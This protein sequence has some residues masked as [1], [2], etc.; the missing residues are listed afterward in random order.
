MRNKKQETRMKIFL[1]LLIGIALEMNTMGEASREMDTMGAANFFP[2]AYITERPLRYSPG[3]TLWMKAILCNP[4][5]YE[6][7]TVNITAN[8]PFVNWDYNNGNFAFIAAFS[9][10]DNCTKP[11][12]Q[13]Q[14][15][16][17]DETRYSCSFPISDLSKA[18]I[19]IRTTAG[20]GANLDITYNTNL[21]CP[22]SVLSGKTF[23]RESKEF[24]P[25]KE[26]E[27][28]KSNCPSTSTLLR[29]VVQMEGDGTVRTSQDPSDY[30]RF[31]FQLCGNEINPINVRSITIGI[32]IDSVMT[33]FICRYD[34]NKPC[35]VTGSPSS[36][37]DP[38]P[39]GLNTM[40]FVLTNTQPQRFSA[41]V[42][43]W[44][45][46]RGLNVFRS[47]TTSLT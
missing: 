30:Y 8:S 34:P 6:G 1:F 23:M 17:G 39:S 5:I 27:N 18:D 15:E 36:W 20:E 33:T 9:S 4:Q 46:Y 2:S 35:T 11:L 7:C 32:D 43:G 19:Y 41:F 10:L 26:Q 45:K 14:P 12:C 47:S 22:S 21:E 38:L 3:Q 29:E 37:H 31:E 16:A 42:E 28:V 13:N 44:G 24:I 25:T 40:V